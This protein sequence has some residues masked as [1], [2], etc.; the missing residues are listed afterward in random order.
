MTVRHVV[1]LALTD[2]TERLLVASLLAHLLIACSL[3]SHANTQTPTCVSTVLCQ[4][5]CKE[6]TES[7]DLFMTVP[8]QLCFIKHISSPAL[9]HLFKTDLMFNWSVLFLQFSISKVLLDEFCDCLSNQIHKTTY[10]HTHTLSDFKC[11]TCSV[12]ILKNCS[13]STPNSKYLIKNIPDCTPGIE[14]KHNKTHL[15]N[16]LPCSSH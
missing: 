8:T 14:P 9:H 2:V 3:F 4:S 6:T 11:C 15:I 13:S 16:S 5:S 10:T 7:D 12:Q 1:T